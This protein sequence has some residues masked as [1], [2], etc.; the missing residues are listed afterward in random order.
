MIETLN[1]A[2]ER[3]LRPGGTIIPSRVSQF[4]APVVASRIDDELRAW[5]R[6]GDDL[7]LRLDLSFPAAMSLNN[8]YVRAIAPEELLDNGQGSV[9]WDQVDFKADKANSPNRSGQAAWPITNGA[10]VYGLCVWWV[11]Q[12]VPGAALST[13][14]DATQTH[15][16]QLY[17]PLLEPMACQAGETLK[18][19]LRSR[20]SE[21][22]GTHLAWKVARH[23][24]AGKVIA[25]QSLDLD[26]GF[27]P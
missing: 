22:E 4:V 6:V 7:G 11:A 15:W 5:E 19:S 13:A 23:D 21:A 8:V 10:T 17:F 18:A 12:L 25:R 3:H 27:L 20:T 16:E 14:P 26:K 1:D 9:C 24:A 2:R